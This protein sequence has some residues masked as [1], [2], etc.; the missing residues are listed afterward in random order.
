MHAGVAF[1]VW[2]PHADAVYV[3]G[4]FNHW[5]P[6]SHAMQRRE[7]GL[8]V[9]G[10]RYAAIGDEYRYRILNGDK[11]MMRL[12]PYAR[13]VTSSVGNAVVHDPQFDWQGDDFHLPPIN[14][15]VIYEMHWGLSTTPRMDHD[16]FE[17]TLQKLDYLKQLGVNVIEVM[18]L[19]EFGGYIHGA[20]TLL[21][22][23]GRGEL[24]R[25]IGF[26]RFVKAVHQAG[27]G[28]VLDVVYN[29]FGPTTW[30]FGSLMAGVKTDWGKLFLQRLAFRDSLGATVLTTAGEVRQ[31]IRDN[32]MM[33]L[34][35]YHVDGLRFDMTLFMRPCARRRRSRW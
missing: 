20:I 17:E 5:S 4:S 3:T 18:P 12:D 10:Y 7:R 22:I 2:A 28:V 33:W 25:S 32:A 21:H 35:E 34:E 19:A 8:L 15:L 27:M 26:K 13:Q 9:R 30:I 31:F 6:D 11:Q 1:R 16:S 23:C 24:W 29:H 14:E